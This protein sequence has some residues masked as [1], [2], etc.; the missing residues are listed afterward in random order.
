M[1]KYRQCSLKLPY[2]ALGNVTKDRSLNLKNSV[3]WY[4][5]SIYI[6]IDTEM[7]EKTIGIKMEAR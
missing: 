6:Y 5:S 1:D 3:Y 7:I 4:Q 2:I